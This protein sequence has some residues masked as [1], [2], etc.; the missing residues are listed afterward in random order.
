MV[1]DIS[2]NS[3]RP[4]RRISTNVPGL[5]C[6]RVT[7]QATFAVS[8][9][10][11][12]QVPFY[13]IEIEDVRGEVL[14][15]KHYRPCSCTR[16]V[17]Q[18]AHYY[19]EEHRG[20]AGLQ[21]H[22]LVM[23]ESLSGLMGQLPLINYV[24]APTTAIRDSREI[25][26]AGRSANLNFLIQHCIV[27]SSLPERHVSMAR[28]VLNATLQLVDGCGSVAVARY[29]GSLEKPSVAS[30]LYECDGNSCHLHS[31]ERSISGRFSPRLTG[32]YEC[33]L[34]NGS[35]EPQGS[36]RGCEF[37]EFFNDVKIRC[38]TL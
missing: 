4:I 22:M 8:V 11:N 38:Q 6:S 12:S 17:Q 37:Q 10:P 30:F 35:T 15:A 33:K 23:I 27:M 32:N 34:Y 26:V 29:R 25:I 18:P 14:C 3:Q 19:S 20:P 7:Q 24:L 9:S 31:N 28:S 2:W 16:I 21:P 1:L 5:G 36:E 13:F